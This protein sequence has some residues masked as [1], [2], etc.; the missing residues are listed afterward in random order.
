MAPVSGFDVWRASHIVGPVAQARTI[1]G[2][3]AGGAVPTHERLDR[4]LVGRA[5][6]LEDVVVVVVRLQAG[7]AFSTS[8]GRPGPGG[9]RGSRGRRASS[10]TRGRRTD[11]T[12]RDG[13]RPSGGR[14]A[15]RR[16]C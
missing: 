3:L 8:S 9:R 16:P 7:P 13:A 15:S 10:G 2:A 12:R 4:E 11:G 6:D 1:A 14:R 5:V